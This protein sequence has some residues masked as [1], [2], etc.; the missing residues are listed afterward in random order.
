MGKQLTT[1]VLVEKKLSPSTTKSPPLNT[2]PPNPA[3]EL[4]RIA[5]LC[6]PS[7]YIC[8]RKK[9]SSWRAL[10]ASRQTI[11]TCNSLDATHKPCACGH[12]KRQGRLGDARRGYMPILPL[13]N[14]SRYSSLRLLTTHF[15]C[16]V[17]HVDV[18]LEDYAARPSVGNR[19]GLFPLVLCRACL[20][21]I[22]SRVLF[23]R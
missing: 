16:V 21:P 6:H 10:V 9:R 4:C 14:V 8:V 15:S 3:Q 18:P 2:P 12:A 5:S 1:S 7:G 17:R 13:R 19:N 22:E 23:E 11:S 20:V